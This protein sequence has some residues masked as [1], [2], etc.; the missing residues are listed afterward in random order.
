[1][2]IY[3]ME[4]KEKEREGRGREKEGT[5]NGK[6]YKTIPDKLQSRTENKKT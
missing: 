1:M 4:I 5:E 2:K 3:K 6:V